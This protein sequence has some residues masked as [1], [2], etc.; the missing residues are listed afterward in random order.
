MLKIYHYEDKTYESALEIALREL[1]KTEEELLIK[2]EETQ[3]KLFKS[4][5]CDLNIIIKEDISREIKN[6]IK[7]LGNKMNLEIQIEVTEKDNIYSVLLVSDNNAILIGKD[8]KTLN[9]IQLLLKQ[10]LNKNNQFNIK[11]NVDVS[12][13]KSKKIHS[14]ESEIRK[15][16]KEVLKTKVEAKLDPMNSYERRI[17]HT[18]VSEFEELETESIGE[19][20]QRYVVIKNK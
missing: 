7:E 13:Y 12:N 6:F 4:K 17:V 8:G 19:E 16:A 14:F 2:V 1:N 5:K 20:P 3:A 10:V 11:V 18:I 15:I 9:S